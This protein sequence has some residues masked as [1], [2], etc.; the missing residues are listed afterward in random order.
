MI[1]DK[2]TIL[3][4]HRKDVGSLA[5]IISYLQKTKADT[6]IVITVKNRFA[7]ISGKLRYNKK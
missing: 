4:Y 3:K 5:K 6:E 1:I 7:F 2:F